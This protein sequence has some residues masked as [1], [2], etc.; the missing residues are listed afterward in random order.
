MHVLLA[1]LVSRSKRKNI[2]YILGLGLNCLL[3]FLV[4]YVTSHNSLDPPIILIFFIIILV[5]LV[6]YTIVVGI[7]LA[8]ANYLKKKADE[9]EESLRK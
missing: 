1:K 8:V 2:I 6:V 3:F 7:Y 4:M 9:K 5:S